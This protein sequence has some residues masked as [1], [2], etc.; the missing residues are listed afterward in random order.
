MTK[1]A[2]RVPRVE[3][4][5]RRLAQTGRARIRILTPDHRATELD[6]ATAPNGYRN[7][8]RDSSR[9]FKEGDGFLEVDLFLDGTE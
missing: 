4:A 9:H 5:L 6:F 1:Y 2:P 3:V 7:Q 8:M